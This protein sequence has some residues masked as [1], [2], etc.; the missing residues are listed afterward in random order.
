MGGLA[1]IVQYDTRD[2]IFTPASGLFVKAT[3]HRFDERQ[4]LH[5]TL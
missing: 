2:T 1:G 3:L 5:L 4:D